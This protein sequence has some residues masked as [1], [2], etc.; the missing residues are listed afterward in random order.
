MN[1]PTEQPAAATAKP[2]IEIQPIAPAQAANSPVVNPKHERRSM[3]GL[4]DPLRAIVLAGGM[5]AAL[6]SFATATIQ[7]ASIYRLDE[8]TIDF[9]SEAFNATVL[10]TIPLVLGAVGALTRLLLSGMRITDHLALIAGSSLMACFSWISIKSGVLVSIIAPH[11]A[12]HGVETKEALST[13]N[14]FY[15]MTLVAIIV[16]MF[17]TNLYLFITQRVEQLSNRPPHDNKP[18]S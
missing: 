16:G 5:I 3:L 9:L 17:S 2:Q 7:N 15:T 12:T 1:N 10:L 14:S 4:S 13:S 8:Q 6:I 18:R 11:L